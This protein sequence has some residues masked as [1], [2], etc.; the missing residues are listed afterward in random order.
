MTPAL[1]I[2]IAVASLIIN[3][4]LGIIAYLGKMV[5][6]GVKK[7]VVALRVADEKLADK[8][9]DFTHKDDF[10]EFRREQQ[11]LF[12]QMFDKL[13]AIND[14]VANKADRVNG[15]GSQ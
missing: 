1:Y 2:G 7:D 15:T 12:R 5:I 13:D 8:L 4:M 14:K 3:L 9:S 11:D 6:D 10:K